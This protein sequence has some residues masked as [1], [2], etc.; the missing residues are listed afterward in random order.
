MLMFIIK[1]IMKFIFKIS[2]KE[3][4]LHTLQAQPLFHKCRLIRTIDS[5]CSI[6]QYVYQ[7]ELITR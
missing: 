4:T 1:A 5:M 6:Q 3:I 7:L 2:C